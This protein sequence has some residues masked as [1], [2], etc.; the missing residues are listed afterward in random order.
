MDFPFSVSP[1]DSVIA[2]ESAPPYITARIRL[3]F[4]SGF[5]LM[6]DQLVK[7]KV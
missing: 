2:F 7:G 6:I 5:P 3:E 1:A 4:Q